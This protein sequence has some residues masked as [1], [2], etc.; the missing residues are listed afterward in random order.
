MPPAQ[1][2]FC[3][4]EINIRSDSFQVC[5]QW[6]YISALHRSWDFLGCWVFGLATTLNVGIETSCHLAGSKFDIQRIKY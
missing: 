1:G 4:Y 5:A 6:D 2:W 3:S